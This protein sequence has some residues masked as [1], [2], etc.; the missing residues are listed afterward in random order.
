VRIG[1]TTVQYVGFEVLT[2]ASIKID[3]DDDD[4]GGSKNL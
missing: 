2:A 3:D 1:N 4:D